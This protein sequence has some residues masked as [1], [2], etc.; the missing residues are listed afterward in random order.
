MIEN[1]PRREKYLLNGILYLV[2][3]IVAERVAAY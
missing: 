2:P 1:I 3:F